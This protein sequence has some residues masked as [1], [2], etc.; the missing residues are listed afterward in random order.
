MA[1]FNIHQT[2]EVSQE[3]NFEQSV[4]FGSTG[5][6]VRSVGLFDVRPYKK[7][8]IVITDKYVPFNDN[9]TTVVYTKSNEPVQT[10]YRLSDNSSFGKPE[11]WEVLTGGYSATEILGEYE[12]DVDGVN[13]IGIA[14]QYL[15]VWANA[16]LEVIE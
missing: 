5:S 13:Y 11:G 1:F 7:V 2:Q 16:H 3:L 8:K 6:A 10:W 14:L 4:I 9:N 15:T 12:I